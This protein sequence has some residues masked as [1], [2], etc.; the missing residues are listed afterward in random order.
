MW[1]PC[2]APEGGLIRLFEDT[3]RKGA[4]RITSYKAS[5]HIKKSYPNIGHHSEVTVTTDAGEV[6]VQFSL[7]Q[8]EILAA[9]QRGLC[10][11]HMIVTG[12]DGPPQQV[13]GD[14]GVLSTP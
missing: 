5:L 3:K 14:F 1:L 13:E 4:G 12:M 9:W 10:R 7:E 11:S 8:Q 6:K 2:Q